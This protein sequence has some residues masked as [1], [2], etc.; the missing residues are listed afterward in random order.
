MF[1]SLEYLGIR[2]M[3]WLH[4]G[5]TAGFL[6]SRLSILK[7]NGLRIRMIASMN[8]PQRCHWH[9][10]FI[11]DTEHSCL[12]R[13]LRWSTFW[14]QPL[15]R[16]RSSSDVHRNIDVPVDPYAFV[17][18]NISALTIFWIPRKLWHLFRSKSHKLA[19]KFTREIHSRWILFISGINKLF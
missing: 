5:C 9:L 12:L 6:G 18:T 2:P 14:R 1:T 3:D 4:W 16:P 7:E 15:S 8:S 19:V 11:S 17:G 13:F 10:V